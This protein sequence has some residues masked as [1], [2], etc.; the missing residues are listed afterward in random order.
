MDTVCSSI[1]HVPQSSH[2]LLSFSV[3]CLAFA[4]FI[5]CCWCLSLLFGSQTLCIL[6]YVYIWN[7]WWGSMY[8]RSCGCPAVQTFLPTCIPHGKLQILPHPMKW[9]NYRFLSCC[10]HQ[11]PSVQC[12]CT[13]VGSTMGRKLCNTASLGHY[14]PNIDSRSDHQFNISV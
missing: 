3:S 10:T 2:S 13:T 8:C 6:C 9:L 4:S 7:G 11:C 14:W 5:G 1:V 12:G